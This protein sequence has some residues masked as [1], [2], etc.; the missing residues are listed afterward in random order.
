MEG[1][2]NDPVTIFSNHPTGEEIALILPSC[3]QENKG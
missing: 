3:E 2:D 1:G